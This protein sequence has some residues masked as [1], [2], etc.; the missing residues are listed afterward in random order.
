M[1][2]TP[3]IPTTRTVKVLILFLSSDFI[4][5]PHAHPLHLEYSSLPA[6]DMKAPATNTA[7]T[8]THIVKIP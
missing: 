4:I 3:H 1:K 6:I 5:H 7:E 8:I 2:Y